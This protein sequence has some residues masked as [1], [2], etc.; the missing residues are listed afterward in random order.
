MQR[1]VGVLACWRLEPRALARWWMFLLL[2]ASPRRGDV[3]L[4]RPVSSDADS[5]HNGARSARGSPAR[6]LS[7]TSS[8]SQG[9]ACS[10]STET[11][12]S[13]PRAACW[14]S[15]THRRSKR[16][17]ALT[18]TC[19]SPGGAAFSMPHVPVGIAGRRGA[20][21]RPTA[22]SCR[23]SRSVGRATTELRSRSLAEV[24]RHERPG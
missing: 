20:T 14:R 11:L 13:T 17:A 2:R 9:G 1:R 23:S 18:A 4:T 21:S 10:R 12:A 24:S 16:R 8:S 19:A 3:G 6:A 22:A 15:V 7:D 5:V